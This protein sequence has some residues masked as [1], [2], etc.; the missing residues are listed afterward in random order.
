MLAC[1]QVAEFANEGPRAPLRRRVRARLL[2]GL[3]RLAATKPG[4]RAVGGALRAAAGAARFSALERTSLANLELALG[5]ATSASERR[6]IARGVRRHG[7]R[8]LSEWLRL[9]HSGDLRDEG[10]AWIEREVELDA[11]SLPLLDEVRARGRGALIVT[12]HLGNWEYL[13]ARLHRHG[14]DGVVVGRHRARDAASDWLVAMRRAYGVETHPQ[15]GSARELV[16]VLR[17]G[18]TVGMLCDLE[19]RRLDGEFV[20]LF[21]RPALTM[22]APASLARAAGAVLLPARCIARG[23]ERSSGY[24]LRFEPPLELERDVGRDD[25]IQLLAR[26]NATYERW[27]RETP[28]Q[29]AW[30]QPRWGSRPG[31][32]A[33]VPIAEFRRRIEAS[34]EAR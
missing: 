15:D 25:V 14:L 3:A 16:R 26:L 20:P 11:A 17:R 2:D 34:R 12:A 21:G 29:W 30:H 24:V 31:E 28:E 6:R 8:L 18:G 1:P 5:D 23:P 33:S 19:V 4:A 7:A 22:T 9:S 32:F 27:I 10:G 13:S